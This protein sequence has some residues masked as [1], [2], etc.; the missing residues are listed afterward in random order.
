VPGVEKFLK[1]P[2]IAKMLQDAYHMLNT[3]TRKYEPLVPEERVKWEAYYAADQ[4]ELSRV[5]R[6]VQ[7]ID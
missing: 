1:W 5:L 7:I 4:E 2:A 3:K 6:N